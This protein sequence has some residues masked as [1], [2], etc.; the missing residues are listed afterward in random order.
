MTVALIGDV[1]GSREVADRAGLHAA[2]G[3]ALERLNT[4][5][6]PWAPTTPLRITVGD[7]YQGAFDTVG[8][9][10]RATLRLRLALTPYDVRHGLGR[11]EAAVLSQTPRVEDGSAWWAAREAIEQVAAAQKQAA[12]RTTRTAICE[13]DSTGRIRPSP[14]TIA[15][16]AALTVQDE[17]LGQCDERDLRVLSGMISG[18]SQAEIAHTLRISPSAVSQRVRRGGLTAVVTGDDLLGRL[19]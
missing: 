7:E 19:V 3:A 1:V 17:L 18:M 4:A 2:V 16:Q 6:A 8:A 10:L 14:L 12:T 15:V 11:G 5:P 13:A 9:A